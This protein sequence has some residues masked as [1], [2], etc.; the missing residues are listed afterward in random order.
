LST[1]LSFDACEILQF[2]GLCTEV[3]KPMLH[4]GF[5]LVCRVECGFFLSM[6]TS[7]GFD[8]P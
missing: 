3:R 5:M 4:L 2:F 7:D 1:A 6:P 8:L